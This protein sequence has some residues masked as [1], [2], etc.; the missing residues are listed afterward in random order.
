M[1]DRAPLANSVAERV[2]R[3]LRQECLD[4][5]IV[6]NERHLVALL[7]EFVRYYNVIDLT[8]PWSLKRRCRANQPRTAPSLRDRFSAD[9]ITRTRGRH[10]RCTF[11]PLQPV[12]ATGH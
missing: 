5:V 6:L 10:D 8:A 2:V 11:A 4:H 3:T 7:T 12:V 1:T 9:F